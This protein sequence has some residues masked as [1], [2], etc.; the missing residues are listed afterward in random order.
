MSLDASN[1]QDIIN[2]WITLE[3]RIQSL[4][5]QILPYAEYMNEYDLPYIYFLRKKTYFPKIK[6]PY[7]DHDD[8]GEF[9]FSW[10]IENVG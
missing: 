7:D 10:W 3:G 9:F 1:T 2:S 6:N 8:D 5:N 4:N